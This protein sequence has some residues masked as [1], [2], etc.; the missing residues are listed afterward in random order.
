METTLGRSLIVAVLVAVG[1]CGGGGGGGNGGNGGNGGGG[2]N[3]SCSGSVGGAVSLAITD[4]NIGW[5]LGGGLVRI[6]NIDAF[7]V[8]DASQV[9]TLGFTCALPPGPPQVS[10]YALTDCSKG[11]QFVAE[12]G[13]AAD[14]KGYLAMY[15]PQQPN[16]M[17]GAGTISI[18]GFEVE[19]P[20]TAGVAIWKV[21]GSAAASLVEAPLGGSSV[22]IDLTF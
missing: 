15:D 14:R 1:G 10:Q 13:P 9:G 5:T 19:V 16:N 17:K 20:E 6:G 4:C 11:G 21:H 8:S 3:G 2:G 22:T 18:T 7:D 12:L